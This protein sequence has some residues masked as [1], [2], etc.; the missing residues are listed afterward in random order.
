MNDERGTMNERTEPAKGPDSD[1]GILESSSPGTLPGD[2]SFPGCMA[3][4]RPPARKPHSEN[5]VP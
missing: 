2:F 3:G 5:D 4:P 1:T